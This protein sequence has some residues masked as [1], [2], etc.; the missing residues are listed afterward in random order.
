MVYYHKNIS[1]GIKRF[2]KDFQT[3]FFRVS[4]GCW[5]VTDTVSVTVCVSV[6][7]VG[8]NISIATLL[9]PHH[10]QLSCMRKLTGNN[11]LLCS[12]FLPRNFGFLKLFRSYRTHTH[13]HTRVKAFSRSAK[14]RAG[15]FHRW[16]RRTNTCAYRS[17]SASAPRGKTTL[18]PTSVSNMAALPND[19][20]HYYGNK[21]AELTRN[22]PD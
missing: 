19:W 5:G 12:S 20:R 3:F 4:P 14:H 1:T 18:Q 9:S 7:F 10:L 22:S 6:K 15:N 8:L 17:I 21:L 13:T 11:Y 2:C 16:M